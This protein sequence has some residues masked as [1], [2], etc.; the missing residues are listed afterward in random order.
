MIRVR[1]N[2]LHRIQNDKQIGTQHMPSAQLFSRNNLVSTA[3]GRHHA[4][5]LCRLFVFLENLFDI[6]DVV[7]ATE[8]YGRSLVDGLGNNIEDVHGACCCFSS[9]LLDDV[10]HWNAFIEQTQLST[11]CMT[12]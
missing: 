5:S 11:H 8:K 1:I 3:T 4:C 12:K 9:G 7:F 6:F 10:R 2:T